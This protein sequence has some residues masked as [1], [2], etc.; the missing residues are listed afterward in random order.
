M[1]VAWA[2]ELLGSFAS[3]APHCQAKVHRSTGRRSEWRG[4][5][6]RLHNLRLLDNP[7]GQHNGHRRSAE[8]HCNRYH[9]YNP[10]SRP[11]L[12]G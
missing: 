12:F 10:G 6:H 3:S 11:L 8:M 7:R 4:I 9:R 5:R 1:A 2:R